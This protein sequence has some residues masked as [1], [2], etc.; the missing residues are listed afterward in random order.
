MLM[1]KEE[2]AIQIAEINSIEVHYVYFAETREEQVFEQ[3]A[4]D[5][6]SAD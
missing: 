3:F 4:A 5:A 1:T 6:A 2:L